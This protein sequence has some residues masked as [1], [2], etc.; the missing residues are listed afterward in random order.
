V[1]KNIKYNT[2]Q[3]KKISQPANAHYHSIGNSDTQKQLSE[4][5]Q[6]T[7]IMQQQQ[8]STDL[9]SSQELENLQQRA[10]LPA[11]GGSMVNETI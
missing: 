8:A 10:G 7:V 3:I 5:S 4:L 6:N 1:L 11:S 9:T 2:G